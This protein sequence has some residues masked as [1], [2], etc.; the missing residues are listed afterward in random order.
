MERF[1][2]RMFQT[3]VLLT[4]L[5]GALAFHAFRSVA[6]FQK[7]VAEALGR[8]E[9]KLRSLQPRARFD[10]ERRRL[11]LGIRDAILKARPRVGPDRSRELASLALEASEKYPGVD[12]LLL[13]AV[14]IVE[15]GYDA[16]AISHAGARGLYQ[17][18]PSTGRLLARRLGWD[19]DEALLHDP[20]RNTEMAAC[21]LDL[22][23]SAYNDPEMILAE[24]NGGPLNAGYFRAKAE[25]LAGETRDYVPRV[26]GVYQRLEREIKGMVPLGSPQEG[27]RP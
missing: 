22:L 27:T 16:G 3:L 2:A 9:T 1:R 20:V 8:R 6:Q 11:L 4:A 10:S 26:I 19:F 5:S 7:E 23:G 14:G 24:Y 12:P 17:I 15:S 13:V 21:Y 18:H 25:K